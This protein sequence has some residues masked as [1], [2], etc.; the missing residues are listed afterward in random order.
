[1]TIG[2]FKVATISTKE[3]ENEWYVS[4]NGKWP[5]DCQG[6]NLFFLADVQHFGLVF[7]LNLSY[8]QNRVLFC[9]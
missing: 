9:V 2:W 4:C 6:F 8:K 7:Q 1:M 3:D 5:F